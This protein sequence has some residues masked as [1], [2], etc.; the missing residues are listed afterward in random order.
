M[1]AAKGFI[2]INNPSFG[3]FVVANASYCG[4]GEGVPVQLRSVPTIDNPECLVN[5][6]TP[7][8]GMSGGGGMGGGM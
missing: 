2:F 4:G 1:I 8:S 3:D 6:C 5:Y 7:S